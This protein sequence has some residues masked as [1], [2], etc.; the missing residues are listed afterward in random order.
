MKL[1]IISH[2]EHY[3]TAQNIIVGW[4]P[5]ITEINYLLETFDEIYHVAMLHEKQAPESAL[6]YKSKRIKF[7]ALPAVG[8]KRRVDKWQILIQ[9]PKII[10]TISKTLKQ[11]DCYQFRA[12]TGIGTFVIPYL[13]LLNRKKGWF[14]YAGN[15]NQK[16]ASWS[17]AFQRWILKRQGRPV[18]INGTWSEQPDHCLSFENP[19]LTLAEIDSAPE[20]IKNKNVESKIDVCFV[21]RLE[22]AKGVHLIIKAMNSLNENEKSRIGTVHLVGDGEHVDAYKRMCEKSSVTFNFHGFLSRDRVREIYIKSHLFILPSESEGFP[23]VIAEALNYGCIPI[24]TDI[25]SIGDYIKDQN[26]GFL[27]TKLTVEHLAFKIREMLKMTNPDYLR[28]KNSQKDLL[29]KFSYSYYNNRIKKEI[30]NFWE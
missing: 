27:L 8:G 17:Y 23:K 20:L 21:G 22:N 19:C 5:T 2:T 28:I 14:K 29:S 16:N 4:G 24:V 18:T 12:P 7:I 30:L 9:S 10:K 3:K 1:A 25:S 15:W 6:P 26:N 13:V 11:V